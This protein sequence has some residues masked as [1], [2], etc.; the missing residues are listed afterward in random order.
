[1]PTTTTVTHPDGSSIMVRTEDIG[2][3]AAEAAAE[4]GG[5]DC[6]W[7]PLESNPDVLNPFVRR[8]GLPA[9]WGFCD[10]LG[11]DDELL[12]MVPQ[13][14]AALCLL[15]PSSKI[16]GPRR[17]ELKPTLAAQT[18]NPKLFFLQQH[19]DIGNACGTIAAVHALSNGAAAGHFTLEKGSPLDEFIGATAGQSVAAR[20]WELAKAKNLQELSDETAAA[21]ET[22]GAGTDD[23]MDAHFICFTHF[24]GTLYE[25]DGRIVADDGA[26]Y[27]V[28]HGPTT[29]ETFLADAGKVIREEF[30]ARDPEN[31][32]F[33]VTALCKSS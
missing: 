13:P 23:A 28:A 5:Q 22:E 27:P 2:P 3:A 6:S 20:G 8:M 18:I 25:L 24:E 26:A 14:C 9:D 31:Y 7:L 33:N 10:V 4:E 30:M 16:S 29:A 21:G 15:F 17:A 11:L 1:M 32:N 12:M 19:D